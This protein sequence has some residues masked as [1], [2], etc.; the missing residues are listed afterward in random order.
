MQTD[1]KAWGSSHR[2]NVLRILRYPKDFIAGFYFDKSR[3]GNIQETIGYISH[4]NEVQKAW[5][6]LTT[7]TL[8][9]RPGPSWSKV[10]SLRFLASRLGSVHV[11]LV[12]SR[13]FDH[14]A[15]SYQRT[16]AHSP[17]YI[18]PRRVSQVQQIR[19]ITSV[20]MHLVGTICCRRNTIL[21]DFQ[22]DSS[23]IVHLRFSGDAPEIKSVQTLFMYLISGKFKVENWKDPSFRKKLDLKQASAYRQSVEN[24]VCFIPAYNWTSTIEFDNFS[25]RTT[26]N[27]GWTAAGYLQQKSCS[28]LLLWIDGLWAL[29][30][31]VF[32]GAIDPTRRF[33]AYEKYYCDV[34]DWPK[35]ALRLS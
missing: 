21:H 18:R 34:L 3:R 35:R 23:I 1:E 31:G 29:P 14:L 20:Y 5:Q 9:Q 24:T 15:P 17:Q 32:E 2:E 10:I 11:S 27:G 13:L 7:S 16:L 22:N 19:T 26:E 4:G 25:D 8:S 12:N 33:S 30:Q 28:R 6:T